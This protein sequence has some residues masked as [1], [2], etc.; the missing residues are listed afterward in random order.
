MGCDWGDGNMLGTRSIWARIVLVVSLSMLMAIVLVAGFSVWR[1]ATR[2]AETRTAEVVSIAR[3]MAST[4][5]EA[6]AQADQRGSFNALRAIRDFEGVTYARLEDQGGRVVAEVG[7]GVLLNSD[8]EAS[9]ARDAMSVLSGRPIIVGVPVRHAGE[10]VGALILVSQTN[11]LWS[12]IFAFLVDLGLASLFAALIGI[13]AISL[14]TRRITAP[15][16]NLSTAMDKVRDDQNFDARIER[17]THDETGHL[18]DAFN[19]MMFQ[20]R[21]RDTR[22]QR[23]RDNLEVEVEHRT[24]QYRSAKEEAEQANAAKSDFLAT[25]SHEIRT[26]MNGML[27]MAELL[28]KAELPGRLNR[29][30]EVINKSGQ[31]LLTIINDIL[32]FS[33]I[34]AG[35][36]SLEGGTLAP[37]DLAVDVLDVFHDR[38]RSKGVELVC[39]VDQHVPA[40]VGGDPTR[41]RQ[42]LSNLVNNAIKFTDQGA[43]AVDVRLTDTGDRIRMVVRDTGIG[44]PSE[45]CATIFEAFLQ[46][47]QS[48]TRQF[49]GTGLGLAIAKRLI[50]AMDG[51]I[52]VES[53]VGQG[54]DFIVEL[55]LKG[56]TAPPSWSG[57][58]TLDD[59]LVC[60]DVDGPMVED[61]LH[62]HLQDLLPH[63]N[64]FA[65][66]ASAQECALCITSVERG[67]DRLPR[68]NEKVI[69]LADAGD[70][71]AE[72]LLADQKCQAVLM[73]PFGHHR[74][75]A[76]IRSAFGMDESADA[77][78]S[79]TIRST[80]QWPKRRVL[81]ADDSEVN[82]E[83]ARE[84][85]SQFGIT[86][87]CVLDGAA[88]LAAL[89]AD[90][91]DLVLIDCSMPVMDGYEATRQ[92]R[93]KG[94]QSRT[95]TSLPVVA[96]TANAS[97]ASET[98]WKEA[99]MDDYLAKPFTLED[100]EESL[101][102]WLPQPQRTAQKSTD[103]QVAETR[104]MPAH[105]AELPLASADGDHSDLISQE[106]LKTLAELTGGLSFDLFK[107]LVSIYQDNAP[108]IA[109]RIV[110]SVVE[111]D[112]DQL[113][114]AAHALKSMSNNIAARRLADMC[115][116]VETLAKDKDTAAFKEANDIATVLEQTLDALNDR[117][118]AMAAKQGVSSS[119][120][121]Y[122]TPE[123]AISIS[124]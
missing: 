33:K 3:V 18:T 57:L 37:R 52:W 10:D 63:H 50:E 92:I 64:P 75:S 96:M 71:R 80:P 73:L 30:A 121:D 108:Q 100:L 42:V 110:Q 29:Y 7:T 41:L 46:A 95:Q 23:H 53:I 109:E 43:V 87:H 11:A 45:K 117:I 86:P 114:N 60:V 38:A 93:A 39:H 116:T 40:S 31:G 6:L 111:S 68:E 74:L 22:L 27:V 14:M 32:D 15:I 106:G 34:E 2:F 124:G 99:G 4:S 78:A 89:D 85:L 26:P 98:V 13:G 97:I 101:I 94:L 51:R 47:D 82:L 55:P 54:S 35:R 103:V 61:S 12:R 69:V 105:Q 59:L 56:A 62:R 70:Q 48:T 67:L 107:N 58:E 113:A 83:V 102:Q 77:G 1:E 5:A 120:R 84:A 49:G 76:A 16:K 118:Q 19:E 21:E 36:M 119:K 9:N 44:I 104:A 123:P 24:L 88:A 81:V 66:V 8:I 28:A 65:E 90:T 79:D 112:F 25:M 20:I 115:Q 91:Y 72:K 17:T 122:E